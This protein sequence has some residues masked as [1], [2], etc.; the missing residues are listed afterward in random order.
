M[1]TEEKTNQ[2]DGFQLDP[3]LLGEDWVFS[4]DQ[5]HL[6]RAPKGKISNF[7]YYFA[8]V[9]QSQDR[10]RTAF[11]SPDPNINPMRDINDAWL[12]HGVDWAEFN[13]NPYGR[14][15]VWNATWS[16]NPNFRILNDW[17]KITGMGG[18]DVPTDDVMDMDE[19]NASGML[20]YRNYPTEGYNSFGKQS[21]R[22]AGDKRW[23]FQGN[24]WVPA[25]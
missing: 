1:A 9:R 13:Y 10:T 12:G 20:E 7:H 3:N 8:G 15:D 4:G 24:T 18:I 22:G 23:K 14:Q 5:V 21:A 2:F 19:S 17:L 11:G 25:P 16:Q 6:N